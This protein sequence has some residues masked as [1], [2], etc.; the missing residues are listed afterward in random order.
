M[1]E[2]EIRHDDQ[3]EG[4]N[5]SRQRP[6]T[7]RSTFRD[8][9]NT[10]PVVIQGTITTAAR[11]EGYVV[12]KYPQARIDPETGFYVRD[13]SEKYHSNITVEELNE[14]LLAKI[15]SYIPKVTTVPNSP[16]S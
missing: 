12:T 4:R 11:R 8:S 7:R 2:V 9:N 15:K 3:T 10:C 1:N 6:D 5:G 13:P 14:D 16:L